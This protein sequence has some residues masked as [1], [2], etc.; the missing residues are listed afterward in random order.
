MIW[1]ASRRTTAWTPGDRATAV[2]QGRPAWSAA[3]R[4]GRNPGPGLAHFYV[5]LAGLLICEGARLSLPTSLSSTGPVSRIR[6]VQ[7]L[8]AV[9]LV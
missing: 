5:N 3:A 4:R 1:T 8:V 7:A 2:P 6:G 9:D